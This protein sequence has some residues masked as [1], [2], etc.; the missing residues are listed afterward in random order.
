M[1]KASNRRS[2]F[3]DMRIESIRRLNGCVVI[4]LRDYFPVLI[5]VRRY[6]EKFDDPET[7]WGYQSLEINGSV[8]TLKVEAEHGECEASFTNLR[9][10]DRRDLKVLI[11]P[12]DA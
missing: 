12:M 2:T 6:V 7:V 8:A 1:L 4:N 11:P 9:L 3:H 5:G 10:I